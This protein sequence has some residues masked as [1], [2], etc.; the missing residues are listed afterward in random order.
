MARTKRVPQ[1]FVRLCELEP[2]LLELYN[3]AKSYKPVPGFCANH[4]WYRYGGLKSQ[5]CHIVGWDAIDPRLQTSEAYDV[6]YE[7]IYG[8]LPDC[9]HDEIICGG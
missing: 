7:T 9:Q 3:E 6:A 2:R 4:I 5:L 1:E 8:A